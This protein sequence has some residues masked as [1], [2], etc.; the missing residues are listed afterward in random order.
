[1]A[2]R[3]L[4]GVFPLAELRAN[5]FLEPPIMG[6]RGGAGSHG[7]G[8]VPCDFLRAEGEVENTGSRK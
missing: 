5:F 2:R 8:F 3:K 7:T 4:F 6:P 1:M